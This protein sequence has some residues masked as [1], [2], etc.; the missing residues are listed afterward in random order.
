[1]VLQEEEQSRTKML[2]LGS[3]QRTRKHAP[4]ATAAPNIPVRNI[5][6][7]FPSGRR[8]ERTH[9]RERNGTQKPVQASEYDDVIATEYVETEVKQ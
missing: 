3:G 4:S 7:K 8:N 2:Q 5:K 1:M 9:R 6:R